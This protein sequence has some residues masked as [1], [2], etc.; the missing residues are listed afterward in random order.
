MFE[1]K[2]LYTRAMPSC[3]S[4]GADVPEG[5]AFCGRCGAPLAAGAEERRV[6]T[7]LFCDLAGFTARSDRADPEDVRALL[8]PYH[9]RLRAEIERFGGT[10]DK[11]IGDG[12]M[13]VFGAPASHE[14]D[15]ERAVRCGLGILDAVAELNQAQ[16]DLDLKVRIGVTT[17]EA[18]VAA[19]RHHSEG[20]VGDVVNTAARLEGVAEVGSVLV[21]EPTFRATRALFDYRPLAPVRV[22]GKA[23]PLSVWRA[24]SARSRL[25][26]AVDQVPATP[27]LGRDGELATGDLGAALRL[28]E[29][30][31]QATRDGPGCYRADPLPIVARICRRA[32]RPELAERFLDGAD[33]PAARYQHSLTSARAVLAETH[34]DLDLAAAL[35]SD[36]GERWRGFGVVLE[37]AQALLGLARCAARGAR[38]AD[39]EPLAAARRLLGSLGATAL[40]ADAHR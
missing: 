37:Q 17:G 31:E 34:G 4:C 10:L 1:E 2:D 23:E 15:P 5:F 27:F 40:V 33:T 38:T 8:R 19:D 32:A 7:V 6:V 14:D 30:L 24:A 11:F 9:A 13:A 35:Y 22:K 16:P 28:I 25:G 39:G 21:G 3:P 26:V 18:V 29:E 12:V 20:V 36:A